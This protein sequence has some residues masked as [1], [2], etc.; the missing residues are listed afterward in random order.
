MVRI[1]N[2]Q[3]SVSRGGGLLTLLALVALT[4]WQSAGECRAEDVWVLKDGYPITPANQN[5]RYE[6]PT[7][8]GGRYLR[9]ASVSTASG[10]LHIRDEGSN[11]QITFDGNWSFAVQGTPPKE[12]RAGQSFDLTLSGQANIAA[13]TDAGTKAVGLIAT[14]AFEASP[15]DAGVHVGN[16]GPGIVVNSTQ[17]TYRVTLAKPTDGGARLTIGFGE[18]SGGAGWTMAEY[19]YEKRQP[20]GGLALPGIDWG[21]IG[22]AAGGLIAAILAALAALLGALTLR[23]KK[24]K[25]NPCQEAMQHYWNQRNNYQ[26]SV[27]VEKSKW[28]SHTMNLRGEIGRLDAR[29]AQ[30]LKE[31]QSKLQ[32]IKELEDAVWYETKKVWALGKSGGLV[33][34]FGRWEALKKLYDLYKA[35]KPV[36]QGAGAVGA[37]GEGAAGGSGGGPVGAVLGAAAALSLY[38]VAEYLEDEVTDML[39]G[40]KIRELEKKL[41]GLKGRVENELPGLQRATQTLEWEFRDLGDKRRDLV[42]RH[43]EA[44]VQTNRQLDHLYGLYQ[45]A[46]RLAVSACP[47][48]AINEPEPKADGVQDPDLSD[49]LQNAWDSYWGGPGSVKTDI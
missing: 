34:E 44:T 38:M 41:E 16:L 8:G 1:N 39:T 22:I 49:P 33:R 18:G 27:Q 28:E 43:Q 17:A 35:A 21:S 45:A 40:D 9:E 26:G 14:G 10:T 24:P 4:A 36:V 12:M 13:G 46:H 37:A 6:T 7:T 5:L 20:S 31:A 25:L 42:R 23:G 2:F 30:V 48:M 32:A 11:G 47:N 29:R 3:R 15:A 19:V